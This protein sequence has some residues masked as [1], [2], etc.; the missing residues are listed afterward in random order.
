MAEC[1]CEPELNENGTWITICNC[2][3]GSLGS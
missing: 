1:N 3:Y 2:K